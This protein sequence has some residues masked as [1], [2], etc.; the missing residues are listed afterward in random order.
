[1]IEEQIKLA[2]KHV[3]ADAEQNKDTITEFSQMR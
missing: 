1:M 3:F 2:E